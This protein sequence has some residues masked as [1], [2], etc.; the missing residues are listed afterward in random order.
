MAW[1]KERSAWV[2]GSHRSMVDSDPA[3]LDEIESG[4]GEE[5]QILWGP[6]S[7]CFQGTSVQTDVAMWVD[8]GI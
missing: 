6:M 3:H 5:N 1:R 7:W 8:G 2:S 4:L